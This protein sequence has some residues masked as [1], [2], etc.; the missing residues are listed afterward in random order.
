MPSSLGLW[1]HWSW[2]ARGALRCTCG[3][4]CRPVLLPGQPPLPSNQDQ[5]PLPRWLQPLRFNGR[6]QVRSGG[7]F[8]ARGHRPRRSRLTGPVDTE[9]AGGVGACQN[10]GG[11]AYRSVSWQCRYW[12]RP[13]PR[14]LPA[15]HNGCPGPGQ[16]VLRQWTGY[17]G[18]GASP[19]KSRSRSGKIDLPGRRGRRQVVV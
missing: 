11:E 2:A 6:V 13:H 16:Q 17:T 9:Q 8:E 12:P 3:V 4:M 15:S 18:W 14:H 19:L 1:A 5:T 7:L 10:V